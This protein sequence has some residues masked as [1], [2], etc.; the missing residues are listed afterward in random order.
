MSRGR[1]EMRFP[2]SVRRPKMT[3]TFTQSRSQRLPK[4]EDQRLAITAYWGNKYKNIKKWLYI[5]K[6]TIRIYFKT[7]KLQLDENH[8]EKCELSVR[9]EKKCCFSMVRG[10]VRFYNSNSILILWFICRF[11][12]NFAVWKKRVTHGRTDVPMD[13]RTHHLTESWVTTKKISGSDSVNAQYFS[14]S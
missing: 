3:I 12:P 5:L 4:T 8:L 11:H 10:Q 2:K 1:A 9:K 13:G 7:I 14:Q 6:W